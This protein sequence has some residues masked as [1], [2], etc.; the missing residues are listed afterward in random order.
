MTSAVPRPSQTLTLPPHWHQTLPNASS[1]QILSL[2]LGEPPAP[3]GE[4]CRG[5]DP[6]TGEPV[7]EWDALAGFHRRFNK[8]LLDRTAVAREAARLRRENGD[9][10]TILKQYLD[11]ISVNADVLASPANPLLVVNSRLQLTLAER[12]RAR[13]AALRAAA[14]TPVPVAA[15]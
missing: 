6:T 11:G 8:A 13:A 3:P 5:L 12:D 7:A 2:A 9:L 1:R 4:A 15:Q 14:T 10:R